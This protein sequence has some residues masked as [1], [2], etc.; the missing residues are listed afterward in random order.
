MPLVHRRPLTRGLSRLSPGRWLAVGLGVAFALGLG[1]LSTPSQAETTLRAAL[2]RAW[3][4]AVQARAAESRQTEAQASR[5][6]ADRWWAEPPSIAVAEKSDRFNADRGAR[7]REIDLS[8]PLW[9]PGQRAAHDAFARSDAAHAEAALAAARLAL[10]G[11]LRQTVWQVAAARADVEIAAQRLATAEALQADVLR[12]QQA[13]DLARTDLLLAQDETLSAQA[14]VAEAWARERQAQGRLRLLTGLERLPGDIEEAAATSTATVH[15]RLILAQA[16]LDRARA[17]LQSVIQDR[18]APPELSLALTQSRE[19]FAAPSRSALRI[20]IRVPLGSEALN[21]PKLA[22]ANTQQ[23]Q[24]EAEL[25][26]ITAELEAE[27]H[28]AQAALEDAEAIHQGAQRRAG[29][30]SERLLLLHKAFSLGELGLAELMRARAASSES[31]LGQLRAKNALGAARAR[32]NQARG[33]L[34]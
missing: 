3:E 30:A 24:A 28:E 23:I 27:L 17:D 6:L 21:A 31:Q 4:R 32:L 15:P 20:G 19:E 11:E 14:G 2:D 5:A 1:L 34:P 33:M 26:Q 18:R 29:L 22:A 7:E 9:L 25:R 16:A 10:A 12:R 13:G 8:L